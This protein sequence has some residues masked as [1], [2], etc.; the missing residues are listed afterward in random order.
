GAVAVASHLPDFKVVEAMC[1]EHLDLS[2][3]VVENLFQRAEEASGELAALFY[4]P[5][6]SGKG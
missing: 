4:V 2:E 5:K 3:E 6:P 1:L